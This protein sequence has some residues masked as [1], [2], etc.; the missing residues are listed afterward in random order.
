MQA[1]NL[2]TQS[3]VGHAFASRAEAGVRP[4]GTNEQ[5]CGDNCMTKYCLI[6]LSSKGCRHGKPYIHCISP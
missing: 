1:P 2:P 3:R 5:C 4:L 6:G